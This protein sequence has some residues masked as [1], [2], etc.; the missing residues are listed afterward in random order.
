MSEEGMEGAPGAPTT[1]SH[2]A[3]VPAELWGET[4]SLLLG[5]MDV[6]VPRVQA[7]KV[8]GHEPPD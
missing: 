5:V 1:T 4:C 7:P 3:Q 6:A 8:P 2:Q